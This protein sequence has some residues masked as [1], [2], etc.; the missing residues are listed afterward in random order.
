MTSS[1]VKAEASPDD[2][3]AS[4][5]RIDTIRLRNQERE[6]RMVQTRR[7]ELGVAA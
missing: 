5:E 4:Q 6:R 1:P 7:R 3:K 2:L